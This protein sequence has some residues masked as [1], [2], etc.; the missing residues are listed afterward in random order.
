MARPRK[1]NPGHTGGKAYALRRIGGHLALD[2]VNTVDRD[3]EVPETLT[4]YRSLVDWCEEGGMLPARD[5]AALRALARARPRPAEQYFR[6]A[7]ATRAA[8][9]DLFLA[10]AYGRR[11]PERAL[12]TLN[13]S[14]RRCSPPLELT[15]NGLNFGR[16]TAQDGAE[17]SEPVRRVVAAIAAFLSSQDFSHVRVCEGERCG[18]FFLDRSPSKRRRWCSMSGCGNRAKARRH[19]EQV[20]SLKGARTGKEARKR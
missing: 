19:Y 13:E 17:L 11:A 9:A 14:I 15:S 7:I 4:D 16:K 3:R 10:R 5:A 8:A 12:R 20:R 18:W 1:S 2:F 6:R